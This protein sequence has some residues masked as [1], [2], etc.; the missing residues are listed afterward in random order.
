MENNKLN[1]SE[2]TCNN[3]VFHVIDPGKMHPC[4]HAQKS[5]DKPAII[6]GSSG[7]TIS[8][9]ELDKASNRLAH[10][11]REEGLGIGDVVAIFMENHP[12]FFDVCW[13]AQRS[14]L[15]Y[16]AIPSKLTAAE[17]SY[18]LADSGAGMLIS[19]A[20]RLD[21]VNELQSQNP[22]VK[23]YVY[24][25]KNGVGNDSRA[26]EPVLA[27]LPDTPIVD[28]RHGTDMLYSSGTTGRP[29]GVRIP[30]SKDESIGQGTWLT[31]T[32][33]D[34]CGFQPGCIY[35]SPAPLYHGAPLRWCMAV[36]KLGGTTIIMEKFDPEA[37]LALIDKYRVDVSQWVPTHFNRLLKLPKEVR[38]RYDVSSL[39][40]ALHAAAPC[41][42]PVKEK[43]IEWWGPVLDEYYAGTEGM[44]FT[45]INSSEWLE[46]KGS[47][48]KALLGIVRICDEN[49]DEVPV[50]VEGQIY[51]EG[52]SPFCYHNDPAKTKKA[53][54]KHGWASLGDVGKIDEDG[55]LYLTDRKNFMI[56]SGGV[57]IYP[58]EIENLL[59]THERVTDAAVIGA[60][61]E[62]MG[63]KVVAVV[64][65]TD[66]AD[67]TPHFAREL[68]AYLR[69]TLSGVKV[70]R[71]IDFREELPREETGKLYKR[72]LRDE[73]WGRKGSQIV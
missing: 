24:T 21:V 66:M 55:F 56:I 25:A 50:G 62:D 36:H 53:V 43:M 40:S 49:G 7:E 42:I 8:Y 37:A 63:E 54:N 33:Q 3:D 12:R 57:N 44:G 73:Y 60:P 32:A 9:A 5:P 61:D 64:Q 58:Q 34:V 52:G 41:P 31:K 67:A 2:M 1:A 19:S 26:I 10:L 39:R 71:Q 65:P 11:F 70:P 72:L 29:K 4:F 17:V 47:V 48:G 46:H 27:D 18:I 6:M 69:Q 30:F 16:V 51:F 14:G 59:V 13:G 23:Q 20:A 28:Q 45:F 35:L 15:Y 68:E 38:A 22:S